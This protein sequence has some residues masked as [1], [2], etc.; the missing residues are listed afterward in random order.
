[1]VEADVPQVTVMLNTYL[2]TLKL[3][4]YFS[5]DEVRHLM[6]PQ[7][8]VMCSYVLADKAGKLTDFC[9]F[10]HLPSTIMQSQKHKILNAVYSYYNVATSVPFIELMRDML[11]LAEQQGADVMNALDLMCNEPVFEPLKFGKGDGN[12]HYYTYNWKC[13]E[14]AAGEVGLVL[15]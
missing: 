9:S 15:V 11:T 4:Q 7:A 1:M 12:L 8:G 14:V 5:E 2:L 10:Y 6:L 3:A 13:A